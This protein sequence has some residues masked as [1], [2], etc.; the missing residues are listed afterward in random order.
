MALA[1][2]SGE[3]IA[4]LMGCSVSGATVAGLKKALVEKLRAFKNEPLKDEY[5]ALVL[6]GMYVRIK[7]CGKQKRPVVAVIGIKENGDEEI[8]GLKVCYSENATEVEGLLRNIKDRGLRGVNLDVVT[9]DGDK[10]L[11]SAVYAVYGNVRIQDCVFHRINRLCQNAVSGKRGRSMM[12]E[13]ASAFR[14]KDMRNKRKALSM[15]CD[16]WR[17]IEP[18]AISRFEFNLHRCFEI[19]ALPEHLRV[20]ASTTGRCEGLF[21]QIRARI[22]Q[23]GAFES[24]ASAEIYVYAVICQKNWLNVPGRSLGTPLLSESTHSY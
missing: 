19:N 12:K 16:K 14:E 7:Q 22:N 4:E 6:D 2:G 15:F 8:I 21:K 20:K 10:G 13:A 1:A 11:E 5:K 17:K 23:I 3:R 18:N 9:I 24:P